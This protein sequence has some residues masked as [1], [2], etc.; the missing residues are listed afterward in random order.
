MATDFFRASPHILAESQPWCVFWVRSA[1]QTGPRVFIHKQLVGLPAAESL[2]FTKWCTASLL[3]TS[4]SPP[5]PPL[6]QHPTLT[7][8]WGKRSMG[9]I[10]P[11]SPAAK[12]NSQL[13][14]KFCRFKKK[15]RK[16]RKETLRFHDNNNF[17]CGTCIFRWWQLRSLKINKRSHY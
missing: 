5:P 7:H 10:P 2:S 1:S 3:I 12:L 16:G 11:S 9:A 4:S 15:A 14:S 17:W 8:G 6:S 13:F